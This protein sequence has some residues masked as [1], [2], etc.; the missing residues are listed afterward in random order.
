MR[1]DINKNVFIWLFGQKQFAKKNCHRCSDENDDTKYDCLYY[2]VHRY[3]CLNTT[4]NGSVYTSG[5][6]TFRKTSTVGR[7]KNY[8]V[9]CRYLCC[10][11]HCGTHR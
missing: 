5:I 10:P 4:Y 2:F 1:N 3:H 7:E 6:S 9:R 8:K 11:V